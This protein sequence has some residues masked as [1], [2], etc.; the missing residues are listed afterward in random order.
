MF[1]MFDTRKI[2]LLTKSPYIRVMVPSTVSVGM[3]NAVLVLLLLLL[4]L[5]DRA[6]TSYYTY[7]TVLLWLAT[8][9]R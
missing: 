1:A 6:V 3:P 8:V 7:R 4:L 9:L 5:A 2:R